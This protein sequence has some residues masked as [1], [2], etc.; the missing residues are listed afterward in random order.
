[1]FRSIKVVLIV[2]IVFVVCVVL[3]VLMVFE[4][5][6]VFNIFINDFNLMVSNILMW[7]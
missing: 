5:K 6:K 7:L 1:M 2:Q 3:L 4:Y